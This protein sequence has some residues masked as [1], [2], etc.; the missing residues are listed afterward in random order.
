MP[1]KYIVIIID[2]EGFKRGSKVWLREAVKEKKYTSSTSKNKTI[3]VFSLAE[4][5]TWANKLLR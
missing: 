5:I 2:G 4:F 1:E 3:E